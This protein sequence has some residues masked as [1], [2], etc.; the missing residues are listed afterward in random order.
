MGARIGIGIAFT[1]VVL[2]ISIAVVLRQ[3]GS[4]LKGR[5]AGAEIPVRISGTNTVP[6]FGL[7]LGSK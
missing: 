7:N 2:A 5:G 1:L 3:A 4:I 6:K